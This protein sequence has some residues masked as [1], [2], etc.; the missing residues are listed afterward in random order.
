MP[1]EQ[2][3]EWE[4]DFGVA[5]TDRNVLDWR[6]R[7]EAFKT[8]V[9]DLSVR[10]VV[11]VGCNRGHNLATI[12]K[13][14]ELRPTIIGVEPN[15]YAAKIAVS[16]GHSV[17]RANAFDL[18]MRNDGADLVFTSNVLIHFALRD[19]PQALAEIH[20]VSRQFI[21][22]IEYFADTETTIHYRGHDDLL[23]KR[24]F[25]AQYETQFPDLKLV[26]SGYW[27]QD[28]GFDRSHWWLYKKP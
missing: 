24:N 17:V 19:L 21:L 15:P 25:P 10:S 14:N 6:I 2:L 28:Q 18:P 5:Y 4:G 8:M 1:T 3:R 20:R 7:L 9:G 27:N 16:D 22:C 12:S 13:I 11:E 26:N 23:W